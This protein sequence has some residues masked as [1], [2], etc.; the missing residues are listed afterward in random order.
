MDP[1]SQLIPIRLV[2]IG[3]TFDQD[4]TTKSGVLLLPRGYVVS[5]ENLERVRNLPIYGDVRVI[6]RKRPQAP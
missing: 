6:A 5:K 3:M 2:E 4:V 1:T